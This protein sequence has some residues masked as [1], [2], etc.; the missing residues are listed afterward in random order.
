MRLAQAD[1]TAMTR[2]KRLPAWT[3]EGEKKNQQLKNTNGHDKKGLAAA[4]APLACQPANQAGKPACG[5]WPAHV[6]PC[7]G[8]WSERV[9]ERE[10]WRESKA[11]EMGWDGMDGWLVGDGIGC[12]VR[13]GGAM[14]S[15]QEAIHEPKTRFVPE[16]QRLA[17]SGHRERSGTRCGHAG[18]VGASHTRPL[19]GPVL[20]HGR[21]T[22]TSTSTCIHHHHHY[23]CKPPT[24]PNNHAFSLVL[25]LFPGRPRRRTGC[26]G[27]RDLAR[28]SISHQQHGPLS[29]SFSTPGGTA[30]YFLILV[31]CQSRCFLLLLFVRMPFPSPSPSH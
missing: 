16:Q 6:R 26:G 4:A 20:R 27:H 10:G 25:V 11:K 2:S 31:L 9:R 3:R 24:H 15:H 30:K 7:S 5:S 28:P 13:V 22:S 14:R 29:S 1:K 17:I 21:C 23:R 12:S 18:G 19:P 8:G